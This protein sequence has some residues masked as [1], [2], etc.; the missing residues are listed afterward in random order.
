LCPWPWH[1]W[2]LCEWPC[3]SCWCCAFDDDAD[4]VDDEEE[5]PRACGCWC[6]WGRH[7]SGIGM[8]SQL[9]RDR[10]LKN[11]IKYKY[12]LSK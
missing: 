3:C 4:E 6:F 2:P 5:A 1:A 12:W 8:Q 10:K 7:H 11:R 9:Q